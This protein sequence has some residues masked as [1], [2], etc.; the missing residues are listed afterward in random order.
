MTLSD[1]SAEMLMSEAQNDASSWIQSLEAWM[2]QLPGGLGGLIVSMH[3]IAEIQPIDGDE[4]L[5]RDLRSRPIMAELKRWSI[6]M[7][8]LDRTN[9]IVEANSL[10][11]GNSKK[12]GSEASPYQQPCLDGESSSQK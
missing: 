12:S 4:L 11:R 7:K 1:S 10:S 8:K 2:V 6:C 3:I 9:V 5:I